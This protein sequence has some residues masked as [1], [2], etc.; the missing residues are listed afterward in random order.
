[1]KTHDKDPHHPTANKHYFLQKIAQYKALYNEGNVDARINRKLTAS[2][3][4]EI[5]SQV[6]EIKQLNQEKRP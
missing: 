2:L 5:D 6:S 1:M 4:S 3:T